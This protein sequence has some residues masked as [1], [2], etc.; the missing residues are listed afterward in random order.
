MGA[1]INEVGG[2]G[3][4]GVERTLRT[5]TAGRLLKNSEKRGLRPKS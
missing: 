5:W 4:L 2:K 1:Y 3:H